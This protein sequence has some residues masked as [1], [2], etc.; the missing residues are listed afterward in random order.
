MP[1]FIIEMDYGDRMMMF[2]YLAGFM[3]GGSMFLTAI[4]QP[5]RPFRFSLILGIG[6]TG[7]ILIFASLL[8]GRGNVL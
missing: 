6:V 7:L 1:A 5:K 3:N 4:I 2:G 8:L